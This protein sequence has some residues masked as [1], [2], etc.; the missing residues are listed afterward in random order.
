MANE[1][2]E[3]NKDIERCMKSLK[4]PTYKS[5]VY[6]QAMRD[7]KGVWKTDGGDGDKELQDEEAVRGLRPVFP[8]FSTS[9]YNSALSG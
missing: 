8:K 9:Q 2:S 6:T 4:C 3:A 7:E 5:Y 1:G